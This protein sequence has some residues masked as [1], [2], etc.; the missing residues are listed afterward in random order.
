M[1]EVMDTA[2]DMK[3]Y[4]VWRREPDGSWQSLIVVKAESP[5]EAKIIVQGYNPGTWF[6]DLTTDNPFERTEKEDDPN[7]CDG[8]SDCRVDGNKVLLEADYVRLTPDTAEELAKELIRCA[9]EIRER[10][11]P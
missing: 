6:S 3:D 1:R 8:Y 5:Y 9:K 7:H 4:E 11:K 2:A 10:N